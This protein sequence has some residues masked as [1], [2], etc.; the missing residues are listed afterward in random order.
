MRKKIVCGTKKREYFHI[1]DKQLKLIKLYLCENFNT[2]DPKFSLSI[3]DTCRRI[4]N[5]REKNIFRRPLPVMPISQDIIL[6]KNTR[7][8]EGTCKCYICLTGRFIGHKKIVS[9]ESF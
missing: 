7:G 6:P 3:C 4:F 9:L 5:D 2:S 8:Y 1:N